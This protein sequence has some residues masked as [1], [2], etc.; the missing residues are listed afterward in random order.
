MIMEILNILV[1]KEVSLVT[2]KENFRLDNS[3]NSKV[4]S[5]AFGLV[6]EI[7]RTLISER[8]KEALHARVAEGKHI[9]RPKGAKNKIYKL[10][11]HKD[12]IIKMRGYGM[13]C[14]RIAK[15]LK[16]DYINLYNYVRRL[17]L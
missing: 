11:I 7:E 9:G 15:K 6:A 12:K 4:L 13:S 3:V 17:N 8:V 1:S 10:D 14:Y 2:I 5:F 16:I